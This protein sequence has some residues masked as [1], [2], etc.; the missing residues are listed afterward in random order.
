MPG[1]EVS[2]LGIGPKTTF[3]VNLPAVPNRFILLCDSAAIYLLCC[4]AL[5]NN[6]RNSGGFTLRVPKIYETRLLQRIKV[7]PK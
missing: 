2:R 3:I 1:G 7:D 5:S 6:Q 4:Y